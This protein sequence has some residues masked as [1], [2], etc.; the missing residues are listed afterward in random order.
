MDMQG[1]KAVTQAINDGLRPEVIEA[2]FT[3]EN[4]REFAADVDLQFDGEVMTFDDGTKAAGF[5]REAHGGML[6]HVA[7]MVPPCGSKVL[8]SAALGKGVEILAES[9]EIQRDSVIGALD[10]VVATF[11][12]LN[13]PLPRGE[14]LGDLTSWLWRMR[15]YLAGFIGR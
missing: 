8:A 1:L 7:L 3:P 4:L 13:A 9:A 5:K 6:Y 14:D 2:D 12:G 11:G 10:A 15:R